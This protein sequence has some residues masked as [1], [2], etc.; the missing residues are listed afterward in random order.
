M[1]RGIPDGG[2]W[3]NNVMPTCPN[4][5]EPRED[6][7]RLVTTTISASS[8]HRSTMSWATRRSCPTAWIRG[9]TLCTMTSFGK[10]GCTT[11]PDVDAL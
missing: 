7:G 6:G 3:L 4:P 10:S 5:P 1:H 2:A 11:P 8:L 9:A